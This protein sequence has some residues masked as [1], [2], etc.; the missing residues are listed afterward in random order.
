MSFITLLEFEP[1]EKTYQ[2]VEASRG[3]D[4]HYFCLIPIS[5][6]RS[7]IDPSSEVFYCQR[8]CVFSCFFLE[9]VEKLYIFTFSCYLIL[10][11][12]IK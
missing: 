9:I 10:P 1:N 3:L 5:T 2:N 7:N 12:S 6:S 11:V 8:S 4:F